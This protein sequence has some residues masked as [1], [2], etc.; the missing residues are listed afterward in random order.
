MLDAKIDVKTYMVHTNVA[1][2][3]KDITCPQTDIIVKVR[4]S[5]NDYTWIGNRKFTEN[6]FLLFSIVIS[7]YLLTL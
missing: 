2:K 3:R 6:Q 4:A 5:F 7:C 1:V